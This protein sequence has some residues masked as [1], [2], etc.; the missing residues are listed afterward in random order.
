MDFSKLSD[1]DLEA[2]ASGNYAAAS[3]QALEMLA[4]QGQPESGLVPDLKR[5]GGLAL[6]SVMQGVNDIPN[7]IV[8]PFVNLYNMATDSKVPTFSQR[9]EALYN[10]MGLPEPQGSEK[11]A[12]TGM[13]VLTGAGGLG[14]LSKLAQGGSGVVGGLLNELASKPAAQLASSLAAQGAVESAQSGGITNPYALMG[15]GMMGGVGG[16]M[17]SAA[18][19]NL[20]Q[21][22]GRGGQ[23]LAQPLYSSGKEQIV[24]RVLN[25]VARDPKQAIANMTDTSPLIKNS[26]LTTAA[27]SRDPGLAGAETAIRAL[28]QSN[29][30]GQRIG[31]QNVARSEVLQKLAGIGEK[32]NIAYAKEKR[33]S[34]TSPMREG[35][36]SAAGNVDETEI[37]NVIDRQMRGTKAVQPQVSR[38]LEFARA[39]VSKANGQPDRLYE[40]KKA[41]Q[42]AR[43]GQY[44]AN[45]DAPM[46]LAGG[47][48]KQIE[49]AIDTAIEQAAPGYKAYLQKYAK[50]SRPIDQMELMRDVFKA[51]TKG[52]ADLATQTPVITA[53]TLRNQFAQ[54]SDL[55][56][57][58][59]SK[60]QQ[61]LAKRLIQDIDRGMAAT[62]P[63]VK[64]PGSDTFKNLSMGN[65]IGRM[66]SEGMQDN[67]TARAIVKPLDWLY[68]MP[69]Q[70]LNELLVDA[71]LDPVLARELMKRA[72]N[73]TIIKVSERLKQNAASTG[74]GSIVGANQ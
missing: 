17:G 41:I 71:M 25:Q 21:R 2:I 22:V 74:Y 3:D 1:K 18:S 30:F 70:A 26:L 12:N 63:G 14:A 11:Y 19:G 24:G 43:L 44:D 51:S 60:S 20:A 48:L 36:F 29:K 52:Q 5:A 40:A 55:M 10:K 73:S 39:Q 46:R 37:I 66:F 62:A 58:T 8:D 38:A 4:A 15:V 33:N 49:M 6:R 68:S 50:M 56:A 42:N 65:L 13:R 23:S 67:S 35:A 45:S 59:L 69:N 31:Q 47:E 7:M 57:D 32:D 72:D 64:V 53:S 28:D 27:A 61:T 9:Q 16:G 54:K 34:I